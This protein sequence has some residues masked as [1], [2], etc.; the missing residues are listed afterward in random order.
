MSKEVTLGLLSFCL[1]IIEDS[2]VATVRKSA[3]I[4]HHEESHTAS[5]YALGNSVREMSASRPKIGS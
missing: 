1:I 2:N 4:M 3:C 5:L